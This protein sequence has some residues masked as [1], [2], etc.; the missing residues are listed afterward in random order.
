MEYFDIGV[1]SV[2]Y[3]KSGEL[4]HEVQIVRDGQNGG[5]E[6]LTI[7]RA[8]LLELVQ[9]ELKVYLTRFIDIHTF[10]T[11]ILTNPY[12]P[13]TRVE[14]CKVSGKFYLKFSSETSP[15]DDLG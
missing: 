8:R 15:C 7:D 14:C 6:T 9:S 13:L 3:E 5:Y 2:I 4:I 12:P 11:N 1:L 10:S